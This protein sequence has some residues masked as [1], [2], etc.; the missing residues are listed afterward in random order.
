MVGAKY[1]TDFAPGLHVHHKDGNM[2]D[3]HP[4]NLKM[5]TPSEHAT[6]HNI[7]EQRHLMGGERF[8]FLYET[9]ENFR[10]NINKGLHSAEAKRKADEGRRRFLDAN[11]DHSRSNQKKSSAIRW[12]KSD[13]R[14]NQAEVARLNFSRKDIT[15]ESVTKALLEAGSKRGASRILNA[16]R[17]VFKRF[18]DVIDQFEKGTLCSNH[19]VMSVKSVEG[20][21]PTYCLTAPETGNF[22]LSAGVFVNN[23]GII[24]NA[25]PAEAGWHGYLTLEFSNSSKADCRIYANEGVVQL[26]FMEGEPCDTTYA[27]RRG[28]Y[29]AQEPQVTL[30]RI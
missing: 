22:A 12:A 11:P 16:D 18:P 28:K 29:Q 6:H 26:L 20:T 23:C 30:A 3:S 19:K 5:L 27:D 15:A 14:T 9:D 7:E 24:A 17:S 8:K 25:T 10:Q 21:H 1:L 4:D 2:L 13:A